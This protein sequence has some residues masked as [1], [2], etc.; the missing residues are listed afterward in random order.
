MTKMNGLF[1]KKQLYQPEDGGGGAVLINCPYLHLRTDQAVYLLVKP[2]IFILLSLL[3]LRNFME[4]CRF[5]YQANSN[6]M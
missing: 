2:F 5:Q 4:I 6:L 3:N 1:S